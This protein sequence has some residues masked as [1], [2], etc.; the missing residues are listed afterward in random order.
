MTYAK[1]EL[2]K[3]KL[4]RNLYGEMRKCLSIKDLGRGRPAARCVSR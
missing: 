2:L 3:N 4:A 1:N